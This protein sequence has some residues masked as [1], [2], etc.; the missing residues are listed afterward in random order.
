[1]KAPRRMDER[2][3][4][5]GGCWSRG[6]APAVLL[7]VAV[8]ATVPLPAAGQAELFVRGNQLYQDGAYSAAIEAY[9]S[10]RDAGWESRDLYYNLGNAYFKAG[11]LGRAILSWERAR[12]L[13]PR[14]PDIRANLELARSLTADRVEPLPRFWLFEAWRWWVDLLP[15]PLLL[16]LVGL[17]WFGLWGGAGWALLATAPGGR[18]AARWTAATGGLVVLLLGVNLLVRA[19][20]LGQP[21]R[22]VVL[23]EMAPVRS[24]PAEDDN[25]T[26]F[27]VHEGTLLRIDQETDDWAEVVLEDGKVGWVHKDVFETI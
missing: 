24:A 19:L 10:V 26:L 18:R 13:D 25:L 8:A 6:R 20:E 14:D 11:R 12:E 3:R 17:G 22:G 16:V 15:G 2:R 9:E 4:R 27:Q 5:A 1:M 7:L 23:V 21:A